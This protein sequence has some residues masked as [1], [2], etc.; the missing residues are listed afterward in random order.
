MINL[1]AALILATVE[2]ETHHGS[3][4]IESN[5]INSFFASGVQDTC[6]A[7]YTFGAKSHSKDVI[8]RFEENAWNNSQWWTSLYAPYAAWYERVYYGNSGPSNNWTQAEFGGTAL[9]NISWNLGMD[10]KWAYVYEGP[11][12]TNYYPHVLTPNVTRRLTEWESLMD[13][14]DGVR[15]FCDGREAGTPIMTR[16][17]YWRGG[18]TEQG[19]DERRIYWS[20]R[21]LMNDEDVISVNWTKPTEWSGA[22]NLSLKFMPIGALAPGATD[23]HNDRFWPTPGSQIPPRVVAETIS[24]T[25]PNGL[26][27][28][29]YNSISNTFEDN[30]SSYFGLNE[31]GCTN[32]LRYNDWRLRRIVNDYYGMYEGLGTAETN[33]VYYSSNVASASRALAML[34]RT[35]ELVNEKVEYGLYDRTLW[36][37]SFECKVTG[38]SEMTNVTMVGFVA[39][40]I[41]HSRDGLFFNVV[42]VY[43]D[44]IRIQFP[45]GIGTPTINTET[46][47]AYCDARW[48]FAW[49]S[50]ASLEYVS[51]SFNFIPGGVWAP[52]FTYSIPVDAVWTATPI[53]PGG[54]NTLYD[55]RFETC[56]SDFDD[57]LYVYFFIYDDGREINAGWVSQSVESLLDIPFDMHLFTKV[58][59]KGE[60]E[61]RYS[62]PVTQALVDRCW[63]Y[64]GPSSVAYTDGRVDGAR[65]HYGSGVYSRK[66]VDSVPEWINLTYDASEYG[67]SY[68][69]YCA[70]FANR[71]FSTMLG[72]RQHLLDIRQS[73]RTRVFESINSW[74]GN[75]ITSDGAFLE[76]LWGVGNWQF[77]DP[78]ATLPI[79]EIRNLPSAL[80]I[81]IYGM[82]QD[83][84]RVN[85]VYALMRPD[86]SCVE[87]MGYVHGELVG[88][89]DLILSLTVGPPGIDMEEIEILYTPPTLKSNLPNSWSSAADSKNAIVIETDWKW[90][91]LGWDD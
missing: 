70:M 33:F 29:G 21:H 54:T 59:V 6:G 22:Q 66:N 42:P 46:N 67:V 8:K 74:Y 88:G 64:A 52:S 48:D 39:N 26:S 14:Q 58:N 45:T 18:T 84:V 79:D 57:L 50:G 56:D 34:D 28:V 83:G 62:M 69:E 10:S 82:T 7:V 20:S 86:G 3:K 27:G 85:D 76:P 40:D 47:S 53:C 35:Y 17:R 63:N 77:A 43:E 19:V 32:P 78:Y 31:S 38:F 9:T 68:R 71:N 61:Y 89:L 44:D 65:M 25:Y 15:E 16:G 37:D 11:R 49:C 1:I 41:M 5:D 75:A 72:W 23:M 60:Y 30:I 55:L 36:N 12:G 90:K 13:L 2:I 81:G 87:F 73:I 91:N 80:N 24:R 4:D 51:T